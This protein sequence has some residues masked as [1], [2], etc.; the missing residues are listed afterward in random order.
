MFLE[1][2]FRYPI[3]HQCQKIYSTNK[4][5]IYIGLF[6]YHI[7]RTQPHT[8]IGWESTTVGTHRPPKMIRNDKFAKYRKNNSTMCAY[9]I[10]AYTPPVN[11][12]RLRKIS[13]V[14]GLC[15]Q[16]LCGEY[17]LRNVLKT[18]YAYRCVPHFCVPI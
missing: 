9:F 16:M 18:S 1:L 17:G 13:W 12:F 7:P 14:N 6:I 4:K 11:L 3:L 15:F 10:S 5:P 8:Y 2:I